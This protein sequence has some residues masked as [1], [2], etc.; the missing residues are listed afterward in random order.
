MPILPQPVRQNLLEQLA[1]STGQAIE[2]VGLVLDTPGAIFRGILAGDPA[3]G[4]SFDTE[5]RVTGSELLDQYGI[6]PQDPYAKTALGL[7][8]EIALDP[9]LLANFGA[10][11]ISKA[12]R[13]AGAAG[14]LDNAPAAAVSK[15]GMAQALRTRTGRT[16][17]KRLAAADVPITPSTFSVTP[18]LGPRMSRSMTTLEDAVNAATDVGAARK[19]L[20][21]LRAGRP[22]TTCFAMRHW[23]A[24]CGWALAT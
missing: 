11:A 8:A 22:N 2:G 3:S 12:G 5:R 15:M 14:L 20:S 17:S 16:V 10:G 24:H 7:A 9:L 1:R 21:P 13:V 19:G 23:V 4:F 18:L 6:A